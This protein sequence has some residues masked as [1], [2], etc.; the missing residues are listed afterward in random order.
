M[1]IRRFLHM[2]KLDVFGLIETR[3]KGN[4][5]LKVSNNI[6]NNWAICTNHQ[7]HKGGRIWMLWNPQAYQ[8]DIQHVFSHTIHAR[9][10]DRVKKR[11]F[12]ITF[13]YGFN[14]AADR[15]SLW[16]SLK[17]YQKQT[18]GAWLIGGDFNNVLF[19]NER[20]GS[21]ITSAEI[22]P[23][24][25]CVH[26]CG[27]EDLKAVGS[28]FTWTNKQEASQRVYS[29][30][31]RV[32]INDDWINMLPKSFANFLPEGLYDHCLVLYNLMRT[33]GRGTFHSDILICGQRLLNL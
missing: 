30:I 23:F 31:D 3:V 27:V 17:T 14:K 5:W 18:T 22:T 1:D 29:R 10:T 2:N 19:P 15:R 33:I 9:L 11:E 28:F 8:V 4:N 16:N 13:V 21:Q 12:W 6:C 7:S 20:V 24:R 26:Y 32:M 25:D